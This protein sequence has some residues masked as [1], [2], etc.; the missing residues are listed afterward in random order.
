MKPEDS[1]YRPYW[2]G[3]GLEQADVTARPDVGAYGR[4]EFDELPPVPFALRGDLAWL[5]TRP[6]HR[7]WPIARNGAVANLPELR[8]TCRRAG[9]ELPD[10]F[11]TFMGSSDLQRRVRSRTACY[12]TIDTAPVPSPAGDGHLIRFLADQQGCLYWYL[13]VTA[14]DHAVV[15]T[16]DYY[17][18]DGTFDTAAP[19]CYSAESFEAFICRYWLENEVWFAAV[20]H[21]P[22]PD[23]GAEYIARYR[24]LAGV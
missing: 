7:E 22:M 3:I 6:A 10:A 12:L 5:A 24:N 23:V 2:W 13:H 11:V 19:I 15:C 18:S 21:T 16:E 9:L 14:A 17:G 1:P 4:Y 20:N 8:E